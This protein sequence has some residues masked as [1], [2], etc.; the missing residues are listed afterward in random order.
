MVS[1]LT[2]FR[3]YLSIKTHLSTLKYDAKA[4]NGRIKNSSQA[5]L[6]KRNDAKLFANLAKLATTTPEMAT[7]LIANIAYGNDYPLE[8]IEL[9]RRNH[10]RWVKNRQSLGYLFSTDLQNIANYCVEKRI[11]FEDVF[12]GNPPHLMVLYL[13][14]LVSIETMAILGVLIPGL[15]DTLLKNKQLSLWKSE[16]IL[17]HKLSSFIRFDKDRFETM[18]RKTKEELECHH[19]KV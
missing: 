6:D 4:H 16:L 8:D 3:L 5:D 15:Y 10:V 18:Y 1:S 11:E 2:C 17:A 13:K 12:W 19:E 9:A 14:K 7:L